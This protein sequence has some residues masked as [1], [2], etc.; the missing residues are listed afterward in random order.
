MES[1][2][3]ACWK[4]FCC[5]T[6]HR[7]LSN[8]QHHIKEL[9]ISIDV[10]RQASCSKLLHSNLFL[11]TCDLYQP[12]EAKR[13]RG[14]WRIKPMT[15]LAFCIL[16][17]ENT[18]ENCSREL[19]GAGGMKKLGTQTM[20]RDWEYVVCTTSKLLPSL[21]VPSSAPNPST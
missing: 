8:H 4:E 5:S 14:W 19:R 7:W 11:R 12:V 1:R 6:V 16:D 10:Q 9:E 13:G 21:S 17:G 15:G 20:D 2:H 18:Q 3:I